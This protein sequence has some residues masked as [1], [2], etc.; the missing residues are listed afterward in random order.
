MA[1]KS[2]RSSQMIHLHSVVA[3]LHEAKWIELVITHEINRVLGEN[4][5][6]SST[7]R[8]YVRI[9]MSAAQESDTSILSK[10]DGDSSLD[11][12]IALVL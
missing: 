3:F 5:I 8:T 6:S 12:R 7:I 1:L 4:I 9:L 10:S 11:N 2:V